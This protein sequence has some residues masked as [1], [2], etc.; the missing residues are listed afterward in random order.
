M[1]PRLQ[2]PA[3]PHSGPGTA[4]HRLRQQRRGPRRTR[5]RTSSL[6]AGISTHWQSTWSGRSNALRIVATRPRIRLAGI[7]CGPAPTPGPFRVDNMIQPRQGPKPRRRIGTLANGRV[8]AEPSGP[9]QVTHLVLHNT[10]E[11]LGRRG[12]RLGVGPQA[13]RGRSHSRRLRRFA[14][15]GAQHVEEERCRSPRC[16]TRVW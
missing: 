8:P 12:P 16:R 5:T 10:P 15:A 14:R 13:P 6:R 7:A 11:A 3:P 4:P 1:I 2:R 9:V